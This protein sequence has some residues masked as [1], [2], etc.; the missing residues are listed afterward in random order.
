VEK[1]MTDAMKERAQELGRQLGQS[2]EYKALARARERLM[3]ETELVETMNRL[4]Q[5]ERDIAAYLQ[6]NMEP[7]ETEREEYERLFTT[8]Q[9]SSV[10]Q[11]LVA[12]QSNFDKLV[13]RMNEEISRGI[14][15]GARSR[16]ILS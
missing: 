13:A 1:Q 3:E 6:N 16:I 2:E 4:D 5:L 11:G 9:A 10:Y 7:G 15:A 12:A 8:L 14:E